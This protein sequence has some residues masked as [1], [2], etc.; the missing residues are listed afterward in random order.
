V[1][2]GELPEIAVVADLATG[3]A[4]VDRIYDRLALL[5]ANDWVVPKNHADL[6]PAAEAGI[7]TER[8]RGMSHLALG[9][10]SSE[11]ADPPLDFR[12]TI[13]LTTAL[14]SAVRGGR[15]SEATS[16]LG[17][18]TSECRACHRIHRD[19]KRRAQN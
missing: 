19:Q 12:R 8:F 1:P 18:I 7:L 14:E 4:E 11:P 6:V 10:S 13:E 16:I 15:A 2:I 5:A 3:M 17:S 9:S